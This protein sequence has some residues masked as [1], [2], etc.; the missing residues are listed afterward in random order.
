LGHYSVA[1]TL[2]RSSHLLLGMRDQTAAALEAAL[3]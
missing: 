2:D 1:K 3:S